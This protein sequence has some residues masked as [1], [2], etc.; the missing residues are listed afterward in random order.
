MLH[1][2]PKP[3]YFDPKNSVRLAIEGGCN[4]VASTF[5]ELG[6]YAHIIPSLVKI[7]HNKLMTY[8]NKF[9][10]LMFGMVK[11]TRDMWLVGLISGR[12]VFQCLMGEGVA[13]LRAKP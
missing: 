2:K 13:L 11:Q 5:S 12:K 10:Q 3:I 4:T 9:D 7:N 1:K 8:P 6:K